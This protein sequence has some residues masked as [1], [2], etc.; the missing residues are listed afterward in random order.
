MALRVVNK[1]TYMRDEPAGLVGMKNR[2]MWKEIEF[3]HAGAISP[4][5]DGDGALVSHAPQE[6]YAKRDR[7]ALNNYGSGPFCEFRV[8][9]LPHSSGVYVYMLVDEPV[10]VGQAADLYARFYAYGHISPKKLL[11]RRSRDELPHEHAGA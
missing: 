9:G 7:V 4:M 3:V 6:R 5:R 8:P 10:Y 1:S 2:W 11:S